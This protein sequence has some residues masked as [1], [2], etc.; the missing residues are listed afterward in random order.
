MTTPVDFKNPVKNWTDARFWGFIRSAL[1]AA[2]RRYPPK[3]KAIEKS[4]RKKTHG[5]TKTRQRWEYKCAECKKHW[6]NKVVIVD[7]ITPAGSL[8]SYKD[9]PKFVENLFCSEDELQVLC[10]PCHYLKTMEERGINPVVAQFKK[11]NAEGQQTELKKLGLPAGSNA[12]K[13]LEIFEGSL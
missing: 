7:H 12:K 1:R 13:R 3:Y 9:L 2:F 11:L 5:K 8:K 6:P 10:K 4:R